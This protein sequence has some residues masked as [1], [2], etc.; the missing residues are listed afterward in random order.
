MKQQ[1][2]LRPTPALKRLRGLLGT[3]SLLALTLSSGRALAQADI[4]PPPPNVL[5]LVDTSGSMDYKTSSNSFPACHYT[6][7]VTTA[8]TSERSRWIDLVEVLTGSIN[9]YDC[10]RLDRS[11]ALFKN[12]YALGGVNPYDFLYTNPYNRPASNGC[13]AGPGTLDPTNKALFPPG[14][15]KFHPFDNTLAT[16]NNFSQS[17]DG[18]LDAFLPDVRFGLMTFDTEPR[19]AKDMSGLWSY[20]L[21]ASKQGEPLGCTVPQDEE[22]GVRNTDAPPWEGRA[23]G[24]GNPAL[25]SVDYKSRNAMIQQVLLATRPY[26]ATPIAGMLDDARTYFLNDAS[27]D[28]LDPTFKFGPLADPASTKSAIGGIPGVVDTGL[29]LGTAERVLVAEGSIIRELRRKEN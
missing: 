14:A 23:V 3:T 11:S 20:F 8:A 18:I 7:A 12:E 22:V 29:F 10:Q 19:A 24:F 25:G 27:A 1:P 17:S 6:G 2:R 28:P 9:N 21:S 16:C 4:S 5:L 26:G 15:I 13:V